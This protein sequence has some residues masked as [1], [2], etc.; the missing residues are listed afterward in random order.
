MAGINNVSN[1]DSPTV[2][3]YFSL[4][5][6]QFFKTKDEKKLTDSKTERTKHFKDI[7]K[8]S[9]YYAKQ[10]SL[11]SIKNEKLTEEELIEKMQDEVYA[12]GDALSDM[13]S[14]ENILAYKKAIKN[15][16]EYIL[17]HAYDVENVI[18]GG[19]NP[20]KKKAWTIVKV[21]N[22]K[23]DKLVSDLM[24]NQVKKLDVL[25][26]IDE[27]KGLIVDLRG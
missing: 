27:I 17:D 23:L 8:E 15:F 18:T 14:A 20:L 9:F 2:S 5:S 21:I 19:V 26:R 22:T 13:I 1:F 10:S 6:S 4:A 24:Y 25:R 12:T 3:S 16:V 7:I 11:D